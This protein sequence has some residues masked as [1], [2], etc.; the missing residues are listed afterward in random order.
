MTRLLL[1]TVALLHAATAVWMWTWPHDWYERVPGVAMMGPFNVHFIRDVALVFG[2]S[3][4]ALL[5]G[6]QRRDRTALL[7]GAAWPVLHGLF[8]VWIWFQ[9]GTPVDV[10]A[11]SNLFGIQAP[12]WISLAAAWR[13]RFEEQDRA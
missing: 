3:A 10:I 7:L 6:L 8:H 13:H 1:G 5:L 4:A 2:L 12:A 11:A 9:R